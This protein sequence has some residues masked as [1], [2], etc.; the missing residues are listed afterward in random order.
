MK[1]KKQ[2][3]SLIV[4]WTDKIALLVCFTQKGLQNFA[5]MTKFIVRVKLSNWH[6]A[7]ENWP[8]DTSFEMNLTL[9]S[10]STFDFSFWRPSRGPTSTIRTT[11]GRLWSSDEV[12]RL[13]HDCNL[14]RCLNNLRF[15]VFG[16]NIFEQME[17]LQ[18]VNKCQKAS[19]KKPR[20]RF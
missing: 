12:W 17:L 14:V 4:Y 5:F 15:K 10:V 7:L 1:Q 19:G 3:L 20:W 11:F 8:A 6:W 2:S 16:D 13:R 9:T 18:N